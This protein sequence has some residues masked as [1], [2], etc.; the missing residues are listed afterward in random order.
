MENEAIIRISIFILTFFVI[1]KWEY[2]A[3]RRQLTTSKRDRWIG[4]LGIV[5]IDTITVRLIFPIAAVGLAIVAESNGWGLLNY[6]NIPGWLAFILGAV[7]MD[8]VIYFQHVLFHAVP[9]LWRIHMVHHADL[10]YDLT[11]GIRFHPIEIVLSMVI[12]FAAIA[13][14]GPPP[15]AILAFEIIL[16]SSAMFNHGNIRLP[17][18]VDQLLRLLI[19]TPDMHRVHH[20]V[21]K[22]ETNSNY[23][24]NLSLWDRLFATYCSQPTEGHENIT[25]GLEQFRNPKKL[26]LGWMIVLPFIGKTGRYPINRD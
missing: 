13:A 14:L 7:I 8:L 26:T 5:V 3:P 15:E 4:N 21:N 9:L 20:S 12:K 25:I 1:A 23:G 19:V 6:F 17:T 10:D 2:I 16:N 11:T 18:K 24:F 22:I